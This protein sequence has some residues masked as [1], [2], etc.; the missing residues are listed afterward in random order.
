[1]YTSSKFGHSVHSVHFVNSF[2]Y[3]IIKLDNIGY[4]YSNVQHINEEDKYVC[5]VCIQNRISNM[6]AFNILGFCNDQLNKR[7]T[8]LHGLIIYTYNEIKFIPTFLI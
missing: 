4:A 6:T 8:N 3:L 5:L 1:M 7:I 2:L